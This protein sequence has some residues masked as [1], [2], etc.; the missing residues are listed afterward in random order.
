MVAV[1]LG[2]VGSPLP[3]HHLAHPFDDLPQFR[4]FA[5]QSKHVFDVRVPHRHQVALATQRVQ[6]RLELAMFFHQSKLG[7][8]FQLQKHAHRID[9]VGVVVHVFDVRAEHFQPCISLP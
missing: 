8:T 6:L 5:L 9:V 2:G 1:Y 7:S 3:D 4:V